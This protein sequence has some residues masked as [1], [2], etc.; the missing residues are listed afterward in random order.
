MEK[1]FLEQIFGRMPEAPNDWQIAEDLLAKRLRGDAMRQP[2]QQPQDVL[3]AVLESQTRPE[4]KSPVKLDPRVEERL[5]GIRG[6]I[7]KST[8]LRPGKWIV[9]TPLAKGGI[10]PF[11]GMKELTFN[12]LDDAQRWVLNNL[13]NEKFERALEKSGGIA[14]Q[15]PLESKRIGRTVITSPSMGGG[16]RSLRD[17][18]PGASKIPPRTPRRF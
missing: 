3:E 1:L 10:E 18:V 13:P 7:E 14:K 16:G 12:T 11:F 8:F 6:T 9:N 5:R 4:N 17:L 15:P 2:P